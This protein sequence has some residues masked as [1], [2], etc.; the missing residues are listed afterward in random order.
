VSKPDPVT[1]RGPALTGFTSSAV[2]YDD[3]RRTVYR[4][5]DGPAV[6]VLHEVPGITPALEAF[7]VRVADAGFT[8]IVPS[9]FGTPGREPSTGYMLRSLARIC[10]SREFHLLALRGQGPVTSWLRSLAADVHTSCGGPGV[11]VVGM[12]VT[13]GFGLAM[14]A[15]PA[16]LAP[17][18]CQPS[19]PL[20]TTAGRRSSIGLSDAD[21]RVARHRALGGCEVVG[22]RFTNDRASP[23][24]RFALLR[25]HLG[26]DFRSIEIDSSPGNVEGI[27][28]NAHSVLTEGYVDSP[29]HPTSLALGYVISFLRERLLDRSAPQAPSREV[30]QM[31]ARARAEVNLAQRGTAVAALASHVFISYAREDAA[32]VR[33]LR[34]ELEARGIAAWSDSEIPVGAEWAE[35]LREKVDTCAAMIVVMTT[36]AGSSDWVAHEIVWALA[37]KKPIAPLLVSGPVL[38]GVAGLQYHDVTSGT[39]PDAAFFER[40]R[41]LMHGSR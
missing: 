38:L 37:R 8:V 23:S 12:C 11:G 13:G 16:V 28:T 18:L 29:G 5:G 31:Y 14:L 21:W 10:I 35:V 30:V 34:D 2:T 24:E 40:L 39:M 4:R 19:L 20:P 32:Y 25:E 26:D 17:V 7:C 22:L 33:R 1:E 9:L 3:V 36:D 6:I 15:E 41:A 27:P